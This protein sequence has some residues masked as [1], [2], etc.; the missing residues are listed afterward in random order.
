MNVRDA[1]RLPVH[2]GRYQ[3]IG[4]L[5]KGGMADAYLALSGELSGLQTLVVVKRMLP[6]LSSSEQYVR[7]FFDEARI[8]ALLDHPNIPRIIE[9]GHDED[10]YFLVMEAVPGK[11]L[12]AIMRRALRYKRPLGHPYSA[13]IVAR[14]A[15]GLAY[16]HAVT[17]ADGRS[18]N[19]VHRDV[20]PEN[21]LVS[22]DGAVKVIDFG[23]ATADGRVSQTFVG[24][25]KGKLEYMS[26]EQSMGAPADRRSDVFSLGIVLWEAL[27][28]RRLF[29]RETDL[30]VMRA[31]SDEPIPRPSGALPIPPPLA[32][33]VM[34]A[35]ERAPEDRFQDAHEMSLLL[36][37][38]AF[39][40]TAFDPAELV[41]RIRRLFPA[42]YAG[43]KA[44]LA[45]AQ[46]GERRAG[47]KIT[48][49]P[50]LAA[51]GTAEHTVS[52]H[53]RPEPD[54]PV[55]RGSP[56]PPTV[57]STSHPTLSLRRW[58]HPTFGKAALPSRRAGAYGV[59]LLVAGLASAT[60]L[61]RFR[62]GKVPSARPPSIVDAPV[63]EPLEPVATVA[64]P[65]ASPPVVQ[66]DTV[67]APPLPA[68]LPPVEPVAPP[69]LASPPAVAPAPRP[70]T[71]RG[72]RVVKAPAQKRAVSHPAAA[73][74]AKPQPAPHP[75]ESPSP[76]RITPPTRPWSDP[77]Q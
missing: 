4:R 13:F 44:T 25:L 77:F 2:I 36:E 61:F 55:T 26:P 47:P 40:T 21:I 3:L 67:G 7:M 15:A 38:F 20:S 39:R 52:L 27:A 68:A 64:S 35:L 1:D 41:A 33:I 69:A 14:A 5:A 74:A 32:E 31:I 8:S 54:E 42:D 60:L 72:P 76:P 23:I 66:P 71:W 53:K 17:G 49:F 24:G 51:V 45:L 19:I 29:R 6:H 12:S 63:I 73:A 57:R 22:F 70:V 28:G 11:P 59:V 65:A 43:W 58:I 18:L 50:S 56:A 48:A 62:T 9:V 75:L 37:R 34:T 30:A 10:G 16:A 46:T